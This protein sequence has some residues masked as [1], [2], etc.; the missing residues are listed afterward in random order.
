MFFAKI[1]PDTEG[2][3]KIPAIFAE[4]AASYGEKV[5]RRHT[6]SALDIQITF[7]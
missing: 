4:S 3:L 7:V 2:D 5:N 6:L 1:N